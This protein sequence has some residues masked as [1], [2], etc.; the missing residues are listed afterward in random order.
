MKFLIPTDGSD[1]SFAALKEAVMLAKKFQEP[2]EIT[3]LS[4][5]D[6][7]GLIHV[8]NY[9]GKKELQ[10]YLRN[11]S[12]TEMARATRWALKMEVDIKKVIKVGHVS[13]TILSYIEKTKPDF[14]VMGS[15]GR[16]GLMDVLLGSVAQRVASKSVSPVL[17]VK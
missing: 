5:H 6:D 13:D 2:S 7:I 1:A 17:L 9:L 4:V 16:S 10:E 3:L 11:I 8:R 15:K 14:V 12:E